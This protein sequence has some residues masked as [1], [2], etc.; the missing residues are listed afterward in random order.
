MEIKERWERRFNRTRSGRKI[1]F[2]I[3]SNAGLT[4]DE[5]LDDLML[6]DGPGSRVEFLHHR[7]V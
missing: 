6:E 3:N 4:D 7:Q 2:Q 5:D 1:I